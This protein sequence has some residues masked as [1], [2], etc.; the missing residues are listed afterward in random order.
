M[1]IFYNLTM[2][3]LENQ[4]RLDIVSLFDYIEYSFVR[5]YFLENT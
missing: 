5:D 2:L 4:D 3:L 1:L